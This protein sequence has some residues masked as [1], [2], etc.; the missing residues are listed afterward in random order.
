MPDLCDILMVCVGFKSPMMAGLA[1][2]G[3]VI[4]IKKN[5]MDDRN[6]FLIQTIKEEH[7]WSN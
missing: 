2:L 3:H 4:L 7:I 6:E 1:G 5:K